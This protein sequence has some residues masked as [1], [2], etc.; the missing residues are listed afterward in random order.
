M[1]DAPVAIATTPR[2]RPVL[3]GDQTRKP[4]SSVRLIQIRWNGIV[5]HDGHAIMIVRQPTERTP[6]PRSS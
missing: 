3:S 2:I 4:Y 1:I 5:S 6:Q